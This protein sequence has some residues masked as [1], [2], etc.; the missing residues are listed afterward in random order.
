M[1]GLK[2]RAIFIGAPMLVVALSGAIS[3][4]AEEPVEGPSNG[5]AAQGDDPSRHPADGERHGLPPETFAVTPG[6]KFLVRLEDEL[7]TKG[8]QE[9]SK[10]KVKT[11]EPLEAGRDRKSTRLNSSHTVISYAVFCLKK[12]KQHKKYGI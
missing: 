5:R 8:T 6:T 12:K 2:L 4:S 7:S 1:N 10:F 11:L 9:N 3:L